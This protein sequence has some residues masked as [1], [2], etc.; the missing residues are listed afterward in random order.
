MERRRGG[1]KTKVYLEKSSASTELRFLIK[2]NSK[3]VLVCDCVSVIV[4]LKETVWAG[5]SL[6]PYSFFRVLTPFSLLLPVYY[7]WS[8]C[9]TATLLSDVFFYVYF[10]IP[11]IS[12]SSSPPSTLSSHRFSP[13]LPL[14]RHVALGRPAPVRQQ[15]RAQTRPVQRL[16]AR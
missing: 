15:S 1:K 3:L 4:F 6:C 8:F 14:S 7:S 10:L 2:E 9:Q 16:G 13:F 5:A 11:F 12:F